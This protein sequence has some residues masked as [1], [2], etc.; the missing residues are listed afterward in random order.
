VDLA[1]LAAAEP[2]DQ[3][4]GARVRADHARVDR[5]ELERRVGHR[6]VEP[7]HHVHVGEEAG[8]RGQVVL[9]DVVRQVAELLVARQRRDRAHH[10]LVRQPRDR[11]VLAVHDDDVGGRRR[12]VR[13]LDGDLAA[14]EVRVDVLAL[15]RV[16]DQHL[17]TLVGEHQ[18]G[19]SAAQ[20]ISLLDDADALVR[21][22]RR[23]RREGAA[24]LV[25][26]GAQRRRGA[27][28]ERRGRRAQHPDASTRIHRGLRTCNSIPILRCE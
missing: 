20:Q 14:V 23:G 7:A 8:E 17:G 16:D 6:P 22:A 24:V 11:A 3:R 10:D 18:P 1:A 2:V 19:Q 21:E 13:L 4:G 5:A 9:V 28:A 15:R 12:H 26:R 27:A 25:G